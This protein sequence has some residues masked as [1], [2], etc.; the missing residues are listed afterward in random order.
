M[1]FL[2]LIKESEWHGIVEDDSI[3]SNFLSF[4]SCFNNVYIDIRLEFVIYLN[5]V[6]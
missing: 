1:K 4:Y 2:S 5:E 3:P 6:F